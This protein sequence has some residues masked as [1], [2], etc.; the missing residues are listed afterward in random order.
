[1]TNSDYAFGLVF[2]TFNSLKQF[3]KL[4]LKPGFKK[5]KL[6]KTRKFFACFMNVQSSCSFFYVIFIKDALFHAVVQR[7]Q[8]A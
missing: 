8:R 7:D 1:M 3:C 2:S 6:K 5:I 4:D